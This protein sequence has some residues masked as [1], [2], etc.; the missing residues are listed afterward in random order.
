MTVGDIGAGSGYHTV[1][2]T[3]YKLAGGGGS[4]PRRF[5]LPI[6]VGR[7]TVE[8]GKLHTEIVELSVEN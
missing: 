3:T 2:V 1:T 7:M 6:A 4:G 8:H 5:R